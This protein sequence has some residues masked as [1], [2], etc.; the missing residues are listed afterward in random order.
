[1][2]HL[3]EVEKYGEIIT[4]DGENAGKSKRRKKDKVVYDPS[5]VAGSSKLKKR[6]SSRI[7]TDDERETSDSDNDVLPTPP[8]LDFDA[9]GISVG[10]YV[11]WT[12]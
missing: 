5:N 1:M 6:S 7:E 10:L 11:L 3:P 9:T 2:K 4:T 12:K 8:S